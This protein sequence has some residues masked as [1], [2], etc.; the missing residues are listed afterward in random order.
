MVQWNRILDMKIVSVGGGGGGGDEGLSGFHFCFLT[1]SR[2]AVCVSGRQLQP[3]DQTIKTRQP[4]HYLFAL[5][6]TLRAATA[7]NPQSRE[8][9]HPNQNFCSY[10]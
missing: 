10:L 6:Q 3:P 2:V 9:I 1:R 4:A 7:S 5:E 8:W